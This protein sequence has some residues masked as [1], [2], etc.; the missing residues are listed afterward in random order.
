[1]KPS[2]ISKDVI[3]KYFTNTVSRVGGITLEDIA[4]QIERLH[5]AAFD[6]LETGYRSDA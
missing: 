5:T 3:D 1:M 6:P 2:D 4:K